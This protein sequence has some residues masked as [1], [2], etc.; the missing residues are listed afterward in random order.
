M[1]INVKWL[2]KL[3]KGRLSRRIGFWVFISVIVIETI[4]FIPSFY[5]RKKELLGH[6]RE[7]STAKITMMMDMAH[8][9]DTDEDLLKHLEQLQM[10]PLILG[11]TVY[12]PDG[13]LIG[14]FGEL[15]ELTIRSSREGGK[16]DFVNREGSRYDSAWVT[17]KMKRACTLIIRHDASS[18]KKRLLNYFLRIGGLVVIISLFV[19][20]GAMVALEPIVLTPILRLRGDLV[21]AGEAIREDRKSPEFY[22]PSVKRRDE[23][24]E[25]I[26]AFIKWHQQILDAITERKQAEQSLQESFRQVDAYS[27]A[28]K[29]EMEQ[30]REM[31]ANFLP[32]RL[33]ERS[34]WEF[35]AYFK[36]ARQVS[37]DFYDF[38]ELP[39]GQVGIVI[40]DVCDK[41][42]GAALF[43][44]L[45]RSLIRIFSGQTTLAGMKLQVEKT[46]SNPR[47]SSKENPYLH[48]AVALEAV[49][50]T[51]NYISKNHDALG[52]FATLFFGVLCPGTGMLTYINGGHEPPF[53]AGSSGGITKLSPTGPA[54]GVRADALFRIEQITLEPGD[55]LLG[56][57]D[58][59]T[60]ARS[61]ADELFG[62]DRLESLLSEPDPSA[63]QLI[64]R[65]KS[66]LFA[67]ADNAPQEDDITLLT[68]RCSPDAVDRENAGPCA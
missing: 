6:I 66:R 52:M 50:L 62:R 28:L 17:D 30:G 25:V 59:T 46:R 15:P 22:A 5:N 60:E 31:Q 38:F 32:D 1:P 64:D 41:G 45:F 57:T 55:I 47:S 9:I 63:G 33:P 42:V 18:V 7:I 61:P 26:S 67:F 16:R 58:G 53:I 65:V 10:D 48:Q 49:R 2:L 20:L 19:T 8:G 39:G 43:M 24:G 56:Y 54:V 29:K 4:I 37:G 44:A 35:A 68:V 13:Q 36:P 40:A 12:R 11:G 27:K 3:P 34:G 14:H 51:N 21:N 23:L